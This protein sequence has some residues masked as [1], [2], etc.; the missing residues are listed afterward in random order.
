M[1]Y[2]EEH[3]WM[4]L[5]E[6]SYNISFIYSFDETREKSMKWLKQ[7]VGFDGAVF[8]LVDGN[9]I[10]D[11]YVYGIDNKYKDVFEKTYTKDNPLSW[12]LESGRDYAYS[13]KELLTE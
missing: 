5:N 11:S 1:A 2:L 13:E 7:L 3:E 12:I 9:E 6:I 4:F 8:S 10:K